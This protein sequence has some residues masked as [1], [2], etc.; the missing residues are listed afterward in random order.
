[1]MPFIIGGLVLV[2]V[3]VLV[4]VIYYLTKG[5]ETPAPTPMP[6]ATTPMLPAPAPQGSGPAP[7]SGPAPQ[8]SGPAPYSG[9]APQGSGPAPYSGPAPPSPSPPPPGGY[10]YTYT[11][12]DF[13]VSSPND[14]RLIVTFKTASPLPANTE[15]TSA[16]AAKAENALLKVVHNGG[17]FASLQ[18]NSFRLHTDSS[19]LI[20]AWFIFG[21]DATFQ[22]YTINTPALVLSGIGKGAHD[23]ATWNNGATGGRTPDLPKISWS[24]QF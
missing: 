10:T 11:G 4:F 5:P 16:S 17:T 24:V 3:V 14:T 2:V 21:N 12:P 8:G 20:D 1:M 15:F 19:G 6:P 9:P 18:T 13:Q 23:Q 7:Y 22:A